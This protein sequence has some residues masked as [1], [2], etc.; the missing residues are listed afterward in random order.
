MIALT[1][2]GFN[3]VRLPYDTISTINRQKYFPYSYKK[4]DGSGEIVKKTLPDVDKKYWKI[5]GEE[6]IE[7]TKSEKYAI[8]EANADLI[9]KESLIQ[10]K[11]RHLAVEALKSEGKLD[12]KGDL[13]K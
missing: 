8:D 2:Q 13:V 10:D 4:D 12:S 7:M 3:K 1:V 11:Q 9:Q 6:I 5:S